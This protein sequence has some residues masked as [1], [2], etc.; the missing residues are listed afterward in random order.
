MRDYGTPPP[1]GTVEVKPYGERW[2]EGRR[3]DVR[4]VWTWNGPHYEVAMELIADG[5]DANASTI[6]KTSYIAVAP[7][8]V[9]ALMRDVGFDR[10]Q[11]IDGR[12]FQPV[13]VGTRASPLN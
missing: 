3:Y 2:S 1:P 4:Q 9:E 12:F 6:V 7:A 13:L 10:V 8:R 11:R 5:G